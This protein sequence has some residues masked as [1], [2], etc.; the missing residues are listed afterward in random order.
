MTGNAEGA[1]IIQVVL[2]AFHARDDVVGIPEIG[3]KASGRDAPR[4]GQLIRG[5]LTP[6]L[7]RELQLPRL[8]AG[9]GMADGTNAA[10]PLKDR[11]SNV[12]PVVSNAVG[13]DARV[14]APSASPLRN[15]APA[16]GAQRTAIRA[17]LIA[18]LSPKFLRGL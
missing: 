11:G 9:I 5:L 4:C 2:A 6:L 18:D 1:E 7:A 16:P 13:V 17:P 14:T 10:V 3:A 15:F 12:G 8:L